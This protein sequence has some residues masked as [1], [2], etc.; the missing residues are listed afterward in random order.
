LA[1]DNQP[2]T[3]ILTILAA[4]AMLAG[5]DGSPAA[6]LKP[7]DRA[8]PPAR[9]I[10]HI[11]D[12]H[13]VPKDQFTADFRSAPV[14]EPYTDEQ[15]DKLYADHLDEVEQTQELQVAELRKLISEHGLQHVWV[16]GLT[17]EG[18]DTYRQVIRKMKETE[19]ATAKLRESEQH[20]A[21]LVQ[22][23]EAAGQAGT[24]RFESMKAAYEEAQALLA[25]R[26]AQSLRFGAVGRLLLSG[27]LSDVLPLDDEVA[28]KAAYPVK[29]D[30]SI[31]LDE[32][33]IA[34]REKAMV[35]RLLGSDEP[36]SVIVL[37]AAHDLAKWIDDPSVEYKRIELA[38]LPGD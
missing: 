14:T 26:R 37:G 11:C 1:G 34:A 12:W 33:V 17:P 16:E 30:G 5:C 22:S 25:S 32:A 38:T 9:L 27:E 20:M 8:N 21:A 10:I 4:A 35:A 2:M 13:L 23:M 18:T 3:R 24:P 31:E 28:H 15:I 7:P 36:V 29:E 6:T 19:A